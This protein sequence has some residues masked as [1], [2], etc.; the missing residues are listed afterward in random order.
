V[1]R[2]L[3]LCPVLQITLAHARNLRGGEDGYA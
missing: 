1:D 2:R 3:D